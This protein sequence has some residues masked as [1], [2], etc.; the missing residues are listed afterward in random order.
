MSPMPPKR[1]RCFNV[2]SV[3]CELLRTTVTRLSIADFLLTRIALLET[4][5]SHE[6]AGAGASSLVDERRLAR[7]AGVWAP[8]QHWRPR[9]GIFRHS[10]ASGARRGERQAADD[11]AERERKRPCIRTPRSCGR[12]DC[13]R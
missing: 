7:R 4:H 12:D 1:S 13:E 11:G 2:S 10:H 9:T 8:G 6:F 5:V 3:N